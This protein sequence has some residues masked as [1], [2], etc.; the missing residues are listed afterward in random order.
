MVEEWVCWEE[1]EMET[2]DSFREL[3]LRRKEREREREGEVGGQW[4]E[5]LVCR[6]KGLE[7][8]DRKKSAQ[9]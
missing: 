4:R 9:R 1:V 6:W 3:W 7:H 8:I 2:E 5:A